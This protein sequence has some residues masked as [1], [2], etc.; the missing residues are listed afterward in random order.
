MLEASYGDGP[1]SQPAG[2]EAVALTAPL[3][4]SDEPGSLVSSALQLVGVHYRR[5]GESP[6]TGLDCSGFVRY[7][8]HD[9]LGRDLPRRA[10]DMSR[11]GMRIARD[12]LKPGDL[13][14]F[15]TLRRA[16][17][18]VG[19]YIGDGQFIHAPAAGG[20]VRIEYLDVPYWTKR[21]NVAKRV[22]G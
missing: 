19:I 9:A 18:H 4:V 3:P 6:K 17:S 14:F 11:V 1:A 8:F 21:F 10:L 13:I 2:L 16:V 12:Q 22:D 20:K 7:V 15:S 5:G